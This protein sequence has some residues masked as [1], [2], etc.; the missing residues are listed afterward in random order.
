MNSYLLL[1]SLLAGM[2]AAL[3]CGATVHSLVAVRPLRDTFEERRRAQ[4]RAGDFVYR[5][6]EPLVNELANLQRALGAK[7]LPK[8]QWRLKFVPSSLPY[9]PEEF[10]AVKSIEGIV[11]AIAV[12][13]LSFFVGWGPTLVFSLV[14]GWGYQQVAVMSLR[15]KCKQRLLKLKSRLPFA[16]DMMS[17][18]MTAGAGFQESLE[19]VVQENAE[20]PLGEELGVVR[21]EIVLGLSRKDALRALDRRLEDES[22]HEL[23]FA[24]VKGEELG[25]PLSGI[26]TTQAEQL[27]LK[28]S[29]WAE[30]ASGEAQVK[31]VY[32]GMLIML[33][34][35]LIT[36]APFLL[37]I[38]EVL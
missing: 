36:V 33:A 1:S 37:K 6:L 28:R 22:F 4:L 23:I 31:I 14:V 25:T 30:K 3:F 27:R 9:L 20:H 12:L 11:L 26:L 8:I 24:I 34:C 38:G 35:L 15:D 32:P 7:A 2:S 17:L 5:W 19:T 10:L 18:M 21:Q 16:M 13:P 29:Q